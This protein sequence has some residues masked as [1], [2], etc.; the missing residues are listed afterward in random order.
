[1]QLHIQAKQ[2]KMPKKKKR[3]NSL[4]IQAQKKK[5]HFV[6]ESIKLWNE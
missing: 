2:K 5:N 4:G 1:M 3:N 6:K